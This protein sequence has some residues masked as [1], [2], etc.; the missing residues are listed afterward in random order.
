MAADI[1]RAAL[2]LGVD[3][4]NTKTIAVVARVDGHI[5]AWGRSGCGDIYGCGER[6]ALDAIAGAAHKALRAAAVGA[7]DLSAIVLS[8]AGADW[9]EDFDAIRAGALD[10]G[11]GPNPIVYNDAIGGLRA[12]SPD[13]TGVSV[14]CGTGTATGA[15]SADGRIWHSSFWQG[16]QGAD[17]LG[18]SAFDAVVQAEL[19]VAPR[20][21]LTQ[22]I[23][24]HFRVDTVEAALHLCTARARSHPPMKPLAKVLFD[25]AM[26]GDDVAMRLVVAHGRALGD[27]ALAAARRVGIAQQPFYLVLAGG[28]M[29]HPSGLMRD[30]I[31][32]RVRQS[33]PGVRVVNDVLEPAIGAVML[34]LEHAGVAVTP[35]IRATLRATAP[36]DDVF[37]T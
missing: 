17:F 34:A 2:V 4:G 16:P 21:A 22:A 20:T 14:V 12:G 37:A 19:G 36:P 1:E 25:V 18:R 13:G 27:Y 23:L 7:S 32:A 30:A 33:S 15:R 6:Q 3:A 31:V 5:V 11:L 35:E 29:R 28:V 24:D 9:P 8:A 10:R 26:Q